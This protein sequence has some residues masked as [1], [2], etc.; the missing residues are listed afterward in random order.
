MSN[1][2]ITK[3][4]EELRVQV[5]ELIRAREAD[6]PSEQQTGAGDSTVQTSVHSP[7]SESTDI[8]K[9][10]EENEG[11]LSSQ[12]QEFVT[13]LEEEIKDTNPMTLL[14]V[15]ALGIL[16]GRLLPR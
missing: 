1:A 11:D 5:A 9:A 7:E 3:E 15:F 13:A 10:D 16:I 4:L 12:L 6:T 8:F 14:V 2:A